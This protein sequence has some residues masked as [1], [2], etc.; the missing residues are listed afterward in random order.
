MQYKQRKRQNGDEKNN[1]IRQQCTN[2]NGIHGKLCFGIQ[3]GILCLQKWNYESS[4]W[5]I[6][7]LNSTC[8]ICAFEIKRSYPKFNLNDWPSPAKLDVT[9][10]GGIVFDR[11]ILLYSAV[12][13]SN[14]A[15]RCPPNSTG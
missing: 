4:S 2:A 15:L 11:C 5:T 13:P 12:E 14:V 9:D 8:S 3:M 10:D 1:E 6:Q 7:Q